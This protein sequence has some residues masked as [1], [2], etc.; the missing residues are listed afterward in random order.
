MK[1]KQKDLDPE[2]QKKIDELN[3]KFQKEREEAVED[4]YVKGLSDEDIFSKID[5]L[6]D[7]QYTEKGLLNDVKN[8]RGRL[9]KEKSERQRKR[10]YAKIRAK[11]LNGNVQDLIKH[12]KKF[13]SNQVRGVET[14]DPNEPERRSN[15]FGS[16]VQT[17]G[18]GRS[19]EK[20]NKKIPL[21]NCYIDQ[22]G[23]FGPSDIQASKQV[24]ATLA[25]FEKKKLISIKIYYFTD[26]DNPVQDDPSKLKSFGTSDQRI[27]EHILKTKPTNVLI[28]T[29]SDIR[30]VP[31]DDTEGPKTSVIVQGGVWILFRNGLVS[32]QL[33]QNIRGKKDNYYAIY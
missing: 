15:R 22:S 5:K 10:E 30:D 7:D 29:D 24:L 14:Y 27:R 32:Q 26:E 28:C 23:S 16:E 1:R 13:V 31:Q 9:E 17:V 6:K 3:K 18:R 19:I 20:H 4:I 21:I 33:Q 2:E 11:G 12:I 8:V 25:N